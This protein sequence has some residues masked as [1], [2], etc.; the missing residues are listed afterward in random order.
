[1]RRWT[2]MPEDGKMDL[3]QL[4]RILPA[5]DI[6]WRV[7]QAGRKNDKWW[8]MVVPYVTNRGVQDILDKVCGKK[9]WKNEEFRPGPAG[10][11]LCG[12]SIRIDGEWITKWDGADNEEN[13]DFAVKS[14]LS[15]AMKRAAVQWGIGRFLYSCKMPSFASIV[16]GDGRYKTKMTDKKSGKSEFVNWNPPPL[17]IETGNGS[18]PPQNAPN[19]QNPPAVPHSTA[20]GSSG[21]LKSCSPEQA[22]AI[23]NILHKPNPEAQ[24]AILQHITKRD[25]I[26]SVY[27]LKANEA[28]K[29]FDL[30]KDRREDLEV[31]VKHFKELAADRPPPAGPTEED[32][33]PTES[34]VPF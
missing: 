19:Q 29:I 16:S 6:E 30:N 28:Q 1:M 17:Q 22:A 31:V 8:A 13:M 18:R 4:D 34:D 11:V 15:N 5:S 7:Q 24:K 10:G 12:I 2:A 33:Y 26:T 3:T 21:D 32:R 9:N 14:G 27:Q 23:F 25:N 20:N